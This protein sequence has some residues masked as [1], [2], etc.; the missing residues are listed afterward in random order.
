VV[1]LD[2]ET[3]IIQTLEQGPPGPQGPKGDPGDNGD[4]GVQGDAGPPGPIPLPDHNDL[5]M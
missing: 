3:E 2:D 1:T 4:Q 5:T